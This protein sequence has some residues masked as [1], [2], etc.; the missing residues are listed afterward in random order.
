MGL[1]PSTFWGILRNFVPEDVGPRSHLE[2]YAQV[3]S[4]QPSACLPVAA[5]SVPFPAT[6]P[7]FW[8]RFSLLRPPLHASLTVG[9]TNLV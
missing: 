6:P 9:E 4:S 7:A 3:P 2:N 8:P 5:A 1:E